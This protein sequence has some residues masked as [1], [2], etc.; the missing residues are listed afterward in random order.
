MMLGVRCCLLSTLVQ[1]LITQS[2]F[3]TMPRE[4]ALFS[5]SAVGYYHE[6]RQSTRTDSSRTTGRVCPVV[7]SRVSWETMNEAV[8]T[9]FEGN[10]AGVGGALR[11]VGSAVLTDCTF[12]DNTTEHQ[13][14]A[15]SNLGVLDIGG[16]A[17]RFSANVLVCENGMYLDSVFW[18]HIPNSWRGMPRKQ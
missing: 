11:L 7:R 17:S 9:A 6:L 4:V 13:G 18:E 16:S 3:P 1:T 14:P 8:S 15:I 5:R 2:S 12:V 10:T